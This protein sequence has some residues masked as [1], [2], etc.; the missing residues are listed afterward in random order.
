MS[1]RF[2]VFPASFVV[3]AGLFGALMLTSSTAS[4]AAVKPSVDVSQIEFHAPTNLP[5]SDDKVSETY[6]R[7]RH[8]R[9]CVKLFNFRSHQN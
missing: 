2:S 4:E 3:A 5:S 8:L 7:A 9:G 6:R 1:G